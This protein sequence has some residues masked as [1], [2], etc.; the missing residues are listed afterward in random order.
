MSTFNEK[1]PLENIVENGE[2]AYSYNVEHLIKEKL[3]LPSATAFNL[4]KARILSSGKGL[5]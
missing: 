1:R 4:D 5:M 2:N 3:K